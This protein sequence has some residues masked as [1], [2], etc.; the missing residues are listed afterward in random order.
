MP[1]KTPTPQTV[2]RKYQS[3]WR[4]EEAHRDLKQQFGLPKCQSHQ[5]WVVSGFIGLVYLGY[6][7]WKIE[8]WKA[9][10]REVE[11][12]KCPSWATEFSREQ[13]YPEILVMS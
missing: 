3:R 4:I 2:Y 11:P 12:L 9:L 7:L 8:K 1:L 6:S 13:I 10:Q 5:A